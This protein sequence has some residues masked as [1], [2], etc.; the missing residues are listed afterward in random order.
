[1]GPRSAASIRDFS[2][3]MTSITVS[4]KPAR[5]VVTLVWETG[6]MSKIM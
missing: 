3:S 6:G 5:R 2:D 1:M 4:M